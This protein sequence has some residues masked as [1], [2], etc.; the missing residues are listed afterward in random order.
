MFILYLYEMFIYDKI[1]HV[2]KDHYYYYYYH[3]EN[4]VTGIVLI[5]ST[6]RR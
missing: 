4:C 1:C 2:N 5:T 6:S 3:H